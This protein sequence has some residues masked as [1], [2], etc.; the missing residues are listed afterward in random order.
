MRQ[1]MAKCWAYS[2]GVD[3]QPYTHLATAPSNHSAPS[4]LLEHR[5]CGSTASVNHMISDLLLSLCLLLCAEPVNPFQSESTRQPGQG[6]SPTS[7]GEA[8]L[9]QRARRGG[10]LVGPGACP[11]P[12]CM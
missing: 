10:F 11:D 6:S 8:E 9:V 7:L 2:D 3:L 4:T 5:V 12:G 1:V